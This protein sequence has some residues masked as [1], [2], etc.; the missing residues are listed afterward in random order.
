MGIFSVLADSTF[1]LSGVYAGI[2]CI[3]GV[4]SCAGAP[5]HLQFLCVLALVLVLVASC[6]SVVRLI[7]LQYFFVFLVC[8]ERFILAQINNFMEVGLIRRFCR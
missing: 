2:S 3:W 1:L 5:L 6:C 8:F 4:Q 7:Q